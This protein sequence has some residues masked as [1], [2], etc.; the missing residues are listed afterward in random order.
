MT[1]HQE[2]LNFEAV[3]AHCETRVPSGTLCEAIKY[4]RKM[5]FIDETNKLL[6]SGELLAEII[7]N[8]LPSDELLAEIKL[9]TI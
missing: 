9:P 1:I 6:P 2:F 8:C 7:T 3:I 4:G 5:Q